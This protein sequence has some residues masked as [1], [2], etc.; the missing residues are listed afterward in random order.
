MIT[1]PL[2]TPIESVGLMEFLEETSD[3]EEDETIAE[4]NWVLVKY[5]TKKSVKHF[6]GKV[7]KVLEVSYEVKFLKHINSRKFKW[8]ESEDIDVVNMSNILVKLKD[9][10]V[11]YKNDCIIGYTFSNDFYGYNLN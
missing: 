9:P 1:S 4:E 3:V 6:V 5:D 10:K 11:N 8:P 7:I 2:P